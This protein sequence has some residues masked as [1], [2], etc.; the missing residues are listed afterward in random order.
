[1]A[2]A[3]GPSGFQKRSHFNSCLA[4]DRPECALCEIAGVMR[5]GDLIFPFA[6]DARSHDCRGLDGRTEGRK[7]E[8]A[9]RLRG[10]KIQLSVPSGDGDRDTEFPDG[11]T[12]VAEHR[13]ERVSVLAAGFHNFTGNTLRDLDAF[14]DAPAFGYES[15]YVRA[16]G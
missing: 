9:A 15:G 6:N 7:Y 11:A 13:R 14:G 16:S 10:K 3:S 2:V 12:L 8:G 4:Q 5:N 1:M